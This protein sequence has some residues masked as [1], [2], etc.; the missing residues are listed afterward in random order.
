MLYVSGIF[1]QLRWTSTSKLYFWVLS[2]FNSCSNEASAYT[3]STQPCQIL[4][5]HKYWTLTY[6]FWQGHGIE[7]NLYAQF[8]C[9]SLKIGNAFLSFFYLL[10]NKWKIEILMIIL[11]LLISH[12]FIGK[13]SWGCRISWV[14]FVW[15][16]NQ[17]R[18][19][20]ELII[21]LIL[22][23]DKYLTLYLQLV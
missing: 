1:P 11:F 7:T 8:K 22:Y 6:L 23:F 3:L 10:L 9:D 12:Y 4:V 14:M 15:L 17:I 2:F 13:T 19:S 5:L 21:K 18:W 16:H 20:L